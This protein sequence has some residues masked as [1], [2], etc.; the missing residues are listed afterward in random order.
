MV[1]M[2]SPKTAKL[3]SARKLLCAGGCGEPTQSIFLR[4][5]DVAVGRNRQKH[6][7]IRRRTGAFIQRRLRRDN[8]GK[9]HLP[10]GTD[11]NLQR[12]PV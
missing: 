11:N 3:Y 8:V 5:A 7:G 9:D 6:H 4:K 12:L 10:A 1:V 2:E